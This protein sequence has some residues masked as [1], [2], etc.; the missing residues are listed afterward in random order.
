MKL[1]LP[2]DIN[3][4]I[5]EYVTIDIKS[6]HDH[7]MLLFILKEYEDHQSK[8][9]DIMLPKCTIKRKKTKLGN[10]YRNYIY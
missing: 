3:N 6:L 9:C 8:Y 7:L 5:Y 4:I 2:A 1:Q 10:K